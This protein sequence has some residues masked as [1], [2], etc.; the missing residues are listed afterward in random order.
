M[1]LIKN[2]LL[3]GKIYVNIIKLNISKQLDCDLNWKKWLNAEKMLCT[4]IVNNNGYIYCFIVGSFFN[5]FY[6]IW[7]YVQKKYKK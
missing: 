3:N 4:W 2:I 5:T 6:R 1:N 7:K